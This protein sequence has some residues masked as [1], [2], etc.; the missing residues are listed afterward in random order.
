MLFPTSLYKVDNEGPLLIGDDEFVPLVW[1]EAE[2]L[3]R[4]VLDEL[5][6]KQF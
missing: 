6:P 4:V 3:Q 1:L 5:H 2:A